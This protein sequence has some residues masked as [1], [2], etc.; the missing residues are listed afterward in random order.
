MVAVGDDALHDA[1]GA[2]TAGEG[3]GVDVADA[4]DVEAGE[5]GGEVAGGAEVGVNAGEFA[6]NEA[7]DLDFFGFNVG[8]VDAVGSP[9][10]GRS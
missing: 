10:G 5:V 3:A 6:D 9:C 7:G 4:Q 8:G 1:A 2:E